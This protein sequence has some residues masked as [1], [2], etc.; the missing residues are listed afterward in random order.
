MI[1]ITVCIIISFKI[2]VCKQSCRSTMFFISSQSFDRISRILQFKRFL[3]FYIWFYM[4][5]NP[6]KFIFKMCKKIE[7]KC[8]RI[9]TE[10]Y[11]KNFVIML[12]N[13]IYTWKISSIS[14]RFVLKFCILVD[15]SFIIKFYK[16]SRKMS[17]KI[18]M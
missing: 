12:F 8:I 2:F 11:D 10:I 7:H 17:V 3:K 4:M 13:M 18:C 9:W 14:P 15:K 6:N 1:Y 5:V 16:A